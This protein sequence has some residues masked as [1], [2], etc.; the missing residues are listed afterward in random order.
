[1]LDNGLDKAGLTTEL[2]KI[3]YWYD[4]TSYGVFTNTGTMQTH[5]NLQTSYKIMRE[6]LTRMTE[7]KSSLDDYR[8]TLVSLRNTIDS[9]YKDEI[10]YKFSSDSAVLMRYA[11]R[12]TVVCQEIQPIDS[13]L[14][15]TLMRVSDL[16][17]TVNRMVNKLSASIEQI[18]AFQKEISSKQFHRE[19]SNL[20]GPV[21]YVRRFGDIIS[22]SM[23]K[24]WLAFIFF[25]RNEIGKI[26][27]MLLLIIAFTIFLLNI[28]LNLKRQNLLDKNSR[29]QCVLK[30]PILSAIVIVLNAFQ[31]AFIDPPFVFTVQIWIIS[32]LSLTFILKDVVARYWMRAW[33]I[34]FFLF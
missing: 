20:G 5:V 19:T 30:Y 24:G 2:S 29:E 17:P 15:K 28:K 7:R 14:K 25:V 23:V 12:L 1:Y 8:K 27:L 10:L 26:F 22:F 21:K 13:S 11:A 33:L 9:L 4:I 18:G 6:L 3:K 31:F 32:G 16:Q 34:L